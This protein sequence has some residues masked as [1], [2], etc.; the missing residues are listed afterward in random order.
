MSN[1]EKENSFL[2]IGTALAGG[3]L[4]LFIGTGFSKYLTDNKAPS[5]LTLLNKCARR[6][7]KKI[8]RKLFDLDK[9]GRVTGCKFDLMIC[10]QILEDA[11]KREGKDIRQTISNIVKNIC[12]KKNINY[13]KL[14]K[15]KAFF[16]AYSRFNIITTNYDELIQN[17]IPNSKVYIEGSGIPKTSDIKPIYHIHGSISNPSSLVLTQDDYFKF[18]HKETYISRKLFTVLQETTTVILGYSLQDFNLN[19]ILNESKHTKD[20]SK[21]SDIY[22]VSRTEIDDLSKRYYFST[23]GIKVLDGIEI[24]DFFHDLD[25]EMSEATRIIKG[26]KRM[27]DILKGIKQFSDDFLKLGRSFVN[28]LLRIQAVGDRLN[29]VKVMELLIEVLERKKVFTAEPGAWSQYTHLA[30]WLIETGSL[31]DLT[32]LPI[33]ERYKN[34]V[35]YSFRTMSASQTFGKAWAAYD[36]W[37]NEIHRLTK[38][39]KAMVKKIIE[40]QFIYDSARNLLPLIET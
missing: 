17:L 28:I 9:Q 27:P 26:A 35:V 14:K 37:K 13:S 33:K 15:V 11:Y 36:I 2:E 16:H 30:E 34:L 19:R 6:L 18:Q 8:V 7:D 22:Y 25:L 10:A 5:W 40:G 39:N 12:K 32:E 38:K 4:T 20:E 3:A 23:F 31:I 21:R 24:G 29:D 1:K